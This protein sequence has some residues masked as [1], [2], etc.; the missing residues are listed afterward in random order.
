VL[1]THPTRAKN[2]QYL[3]HLPDD[4]S[5]ERNVKTEDNRLY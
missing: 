4:R 5:I 3:S 1:N 2:P